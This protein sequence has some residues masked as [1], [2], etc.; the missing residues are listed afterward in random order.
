MSEIPRS[1]Q[2][3]FNKLKQALATGDDEM[4]A[5][6]VKTK[7][8]LAIRHDL[9]TALGQHVRENYDE[10][11]NVFNN[12]D[13]LKD[14]PVNYSKLPP[15]VAGRYSKG[16]NQLYLPHEDLEAPNRQM[17]SRLHEYGH[18][19]DAL[20]G[21]E[22]SQPFN[23]TKAILNSSG[24]ESAQDTLG[25]HHS[26]GFFEKYAL[27]NLLNN[28]KLGEPMADRNLNKAY[29]LLMKRQQ[30]NI[31]RNLAE[32]RTMDMKGT[33]L[34]DQTSQA[35]DTLSNVKG[36]IADNNGLVQNFRDKLGKTTTSNSMEG[37]NSDVKGRFNNIKNSLSDAA[38]DAGKM[39]GE[40]SGV[41]KS[42]RGETGSASVLPM[43]GLGAAALGGMGVAK[44]LQAGDYGNATLDTA[45]IGTDF[46]PGVGLAKMALRP[47]DLGNSELPADVMQQRTAYNNSVNNP[48]L[49][50]ESTANSDGDKQR[51][52]NIL[53]KLQR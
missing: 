18:A 9:S 3:Y 1:Q 29:E 22:E 46:I 36:D 16:D 14:I 30:K 21:F 13:I 52:K 44:K 28:K 31:D 10:P 5:D 33:P 39:V 35:T 45:D 42:L 24:L 47:T 43:L 53:A 49:D 2:D 40:D 6:L 8:P 41:V 15:G 38:S 12:K 7:N 23:K 27:E 34:N 32:G 26:S 50:S 51:F 17:G 48:N 19:D 25:K 37:I 11:L 4:L 20:N